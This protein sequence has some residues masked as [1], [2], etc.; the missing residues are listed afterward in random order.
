MLFILPLSEYRYK[1]VYLPQEQQEFFLL[2]LCEKNSSIFISISFSLYFWCNNATVKI[3]ILN[4][5]ECFMVP[6]TPVAMIIKTLA[7]NAFNFNDFFCRKKFVYIHTSS[8]Y[9]IC[10]MDLILCCFCNLFVWIKKT[11]SEYL[12]PKFKGRK[13]CYY[14]IR[15]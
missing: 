1:V 2:F 6:S 5:W 4:V 13:L 11:L 9:F 12:F 15:L 8:A 3:N 10:F 14:L 7:W